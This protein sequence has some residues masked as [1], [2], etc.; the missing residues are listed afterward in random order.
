MRLSSPAFRDGGDI[1]RVFSCEGENISP[2]IEW[3]EIPI[4]TGSL[5]FIVHDPDASRPGGF[6]HW[7]LYNIPP[8]CPGIPSSAPTTEIVQNL[9]M[10]GRNSEGNPGYTGPCPPQS[11]HRYFF[12]L[13]AMQRELAL[14]PGADYPHL[15]EAMEGHILATAELMGCYA[16]SEK[17]AA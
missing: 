11:Q 10:Q 3:S 14:E 1:P 2:A 17:K 16:K 8:D 7:L 13:Y 5:V 9:G 12:R 15:A 4:G 6:Y